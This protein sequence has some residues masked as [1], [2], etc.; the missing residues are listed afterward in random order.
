LAPDQRPWS[1]AQ[2]RFG[3]IVVLGGEMAAAYAASGA[4]ARLSICVQ[5]TASGPFRW[6]AVAESDL[7]P[8]LK[9]LATDAPQLPAAG[10]RIVRPPHE[11]VTRLK[12]ALLALLDPSDN[13][14]AAAIDDRSRAVL[15]RQLLATLAV[16]VR[17]TGPP[18]RCESPCG[19]LGER[20]AVT[21]M[22]RLHDRHMR[23]EAPGSATCGFTSFGD[24]SPV[25]IAPLPLSGRSAMNVAAS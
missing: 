3:K 16:C 21:M 14:G 15:H 20:T 6:V 7:E 25:N 17:G 22:E 10:T 13:A 19:P 1:V 23:H 5:V 9:N 18:L 8:Y 2:A 24:Q 11:A 12:T 4:A